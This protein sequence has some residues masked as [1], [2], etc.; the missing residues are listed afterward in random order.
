MVA[1]L[2]CIVNIREDDTT[3]NQNGSER[4]QDDSIGYTGYDGEEMASDTQIMP[5]ISVT[6]H[7]PKSRKKPSQ[8]GLSYPR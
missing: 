5:A 6:D 8:Y 3:S 7:D 4:Y 1:M 2:N